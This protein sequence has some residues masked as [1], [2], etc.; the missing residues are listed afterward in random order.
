MRQHRWPVT[1]TPSRPS[2]D[3][4]FLRQCWRA[5]Q[6]RNYAKLNYVGYSYGTWLGA[7]YADT[8]P[9]QV[10]RFI[11]DSNMQWTTS[12]YAN[13]LSTRSPSSGAA[14]RCSFPSWLGTTTTYGLGK[15]AKKVEKKYESIRKK[16]A[17]QAKKALKKGKTPV[18]EAGGP[19]L[20]H[21][22]L[23]YTD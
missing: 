22:Q 2:D 7:W 11:L 13:Q 23:I 9:N 5:E 16:L 17:T 4:E 18:A 3:L 10:G 20:H 15:T 14:T 8:Y 19:R 1:S 6:G 12:M 21:G